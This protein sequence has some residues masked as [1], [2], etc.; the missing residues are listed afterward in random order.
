MVTNILI[1][2]FLFP[3]WVLFIISGLFVWK[4]YKSSKLEL[5]E[6]KNSIKVDEF[7][8]DDFEERKLMKKDGK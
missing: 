5:I 1:I 7:L 2:I 3:L 6:Q 4:K 8:S